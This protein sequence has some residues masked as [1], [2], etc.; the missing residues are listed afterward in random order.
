MCF[1]IC[2]N[3]HPVVFLVLVLKKNCCRER[4]EEMLTGELRDRGGQEVGAA[5]SDGGRSGSSFRRN[6]L[7]RSL[8][9]SD[10]PVT[11][12]NGIKRRHTHGHI[13]LH[14]H[15]HTYS[16]VGT[17][18]ETHRHTLKRRSFPPW[19]TVL[20]PSDSSLPLFKDFLPP[21]VSDSFPLDTA[22]LPRLLFYR[23]RPLF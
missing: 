8:S 18:S 20:A 5:S 11:E 17:E 12:K 21:L 22:P 16:H 9:Q 15:T 14:G 7:G 1:C 10:V 4:R 19:T 3:Y 13:D 2:F 23:S 6:Q